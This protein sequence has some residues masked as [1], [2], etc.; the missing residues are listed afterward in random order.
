MCKM[1]RIFF[2]CLLLGLAQPAGA[3]VPDF[4]H[5]YSAWNQALNQFAKDGGFDYK[6]LKKDPALL[7]DFLESISSL[8][9]NEYEKLDKEQK[10]AFWINT[11][12]VLAV[13]TILDH[14]PLK[15]GL[16]WKAVAYPKNSIQQIPNVWDRPILKIF[17][18]DFS[19]NRIE[20]DTLRKEFKEPRIHFALVCAAR[21]CPPLR[22]EA[23]VPERLNA[24]LDDQARQFFAN[25][26]KAKYDVQEDVLHLSSILH[27]FGK[28]FEK[29]GG[30]IEFAKKYMPKAAGQKLSD[31][32]KI[33]WLDYDW[34]LNEKR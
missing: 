16:S 20:H 24:Q 15:K 19:L 9:K 10:I 26:E 1:L 27:W 28:D 13:K 5:Q 25:P 2:P 6:A 18:E 4:D 30:P 8:P 34:S 33:K 32:T 11:Y 23:Y 7:N 21:G 12:N 29:D 14:Y 31:K 3:N 22:M 17:N